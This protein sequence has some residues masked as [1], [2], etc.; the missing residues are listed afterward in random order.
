VSDPAKG[1]DRR[2]R[3]GAQIIPRPRK[4]RPGAPAPWAELDRLPRIDVG[5][6]AAAIAARGPGRPPAISFPGGRHSAVLV[7]LFPGDDGAEVVLTRR[8]KTLASHKGEISFPGGR[9]D[10]GESP[11]DAALREALEE[12]A[13]GPSLVTVVGELDHITTIVSRS[14]IVPVV[15]TLEARP[16]LRASAAEVDRILTLPLVEFLADDVYREERWGYPPLD[17]SIHFFEL[18]DETVWGATGRMMLQLLSIATG[19]AT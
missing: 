3:G 8:S 19:V 13:L 14:I 11:V 1:E 15:G 5:D 2:R 16:E 7:V 4:W 6:L 9:L 10:P 17:R 18:T 12:V